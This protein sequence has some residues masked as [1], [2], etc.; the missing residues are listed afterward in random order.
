MSGRELNAFQSKVPKFTKAASNLPKVSITQT[1][2]FPVGAYRSLY[3]RIY[4]HK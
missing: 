1:E 3:M 2:Y 4:I